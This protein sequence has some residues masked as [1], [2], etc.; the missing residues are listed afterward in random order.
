MP[1]T[2]TA[3]EVKAQLDSLLDQSNDRFDDIIVERNGEPRAVI[4]SFAEYQAVA[5]LR[6]ALRQEQVIAELEQLRASVAARNEGLAEE[7]VEK[8]AVQAG[9]EVIEAVIAKHVN[10]KPLEP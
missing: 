5:E 9:R 2:M 10:R 7:Q 4:V 3:R 6:Q 8:I 1:T